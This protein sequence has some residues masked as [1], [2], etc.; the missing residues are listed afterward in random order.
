MSAVFMASLVVTARCCMHKM[1]HCSQYGLL[2]SVVFSATVHLQYNILY[3]V[4]IKQGP[5][6]LCTASNI[7][8]DCTNE[9]AILVAVEKRCAIMR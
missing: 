4:A 9:I 8:A 5:G 1:T 6:P 2:R 3:Q 7:S